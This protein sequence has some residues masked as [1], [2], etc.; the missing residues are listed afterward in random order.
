VNVVLTAQD[1]QQCGAASDPKGEFT[2]SNVPYGSYT[3]KALY[4]GYVPLTERVL[5]A[6]D[7]VRLNL[8]LRAVGLTLTQAK[9]ESI[10][11]DV[12]VEP[13]ELSLRITPWRPPRVGEEVMFR[14]LIQNDSDLS[15]VLCRALDGSTNGSR[16]PRIAVDVDGPTGGLEERAPYLRICANQRKM[17]DADLVE[18]GPGGTFDP[19]DGE[20]LRLEARFRRPGRYEFTI[21]YSIDEPDLRQ[22]M[23]FPG[24]TT[25]PSTM[26]QMLRRLP[27]IELSSSIVFRV[28]G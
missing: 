1:G 23:G 2:L 18:V 6:E 12:E 10:G 5:V 13:G 7:T 4:L 3:L 20:P 24:L 8:Q 14:L 9:A 26:S 15:I 27:R 28:D 21:T 19:F 16:Y 22:W 17:R 25:I 11:V